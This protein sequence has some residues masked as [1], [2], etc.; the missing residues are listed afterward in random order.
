VVMSDELKLVLGWGPCASQQMQAQ[1]T[2]SKASPAPSSAGTDQAT[3]AVALAW[4]EPE[5]RRPFEHRV[6][7]CSMCHFESSGTTPMIR[8]MVGATEGSPNSC[9]ASSHPHGLPAVHQEASWTGSRK[10]SGLRSMRHPK[11]G[12]PPPHRE[13]AITI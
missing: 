2:T 7:C 6:F 3:R 5:I 13:G 10:R 1:G 8:S 4:L 9:S 11:P 12:S